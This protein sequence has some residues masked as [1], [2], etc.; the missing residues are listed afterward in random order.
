M[1][2][3]FSFTMSGCKILTLGLAPPPSGAVAS[4]ISQRSVGQ[5]LEWT[6]IILPSIKLYELRSKTEARFSAC[7]P[8]GISICTLT[9]SVIISH[10]LLESRQLCGCC[11]MGKKRER[12]GKLDGTN[13]VDISLNW[14]VLMFISQLQFQGLHKPYKQGL[15]FVIHISSSH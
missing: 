2:L 14:R 7:A 15:I 1:V 5:F 12:E 6:L 8:C 4:A 3:N 9:F 11:E 13:G 10:A